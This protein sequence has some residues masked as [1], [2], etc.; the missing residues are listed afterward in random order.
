MFKVEHSCARANELLVTSKGGA[1]GC[2]PGRAHRLVT[3]TAVQ[4][5]H[6]KFDLTKEGRSH[7]SLFSPRG[8]KLPAPFYRRR[9]EIAKPGATDARGVAAVRSTD[10]VRR[11][12]FHTT[13][14]R[15]RGSQPL[16]NCIL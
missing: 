13:P 3:A 14:L 11:P 12:E 15:R 16:Q 7:C 6:G 9:S 5:R 1:R 4:L 2:S 10:I 8:L